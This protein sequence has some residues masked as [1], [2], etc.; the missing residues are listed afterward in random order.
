[1]KYPEI[2][3][4]YKFYAYYENSLSVLINRT[5]WSAKPDSFNDP[6][7]CKI[8]FNNYINLQE[9]EHFLPRY[10]NFKGISEKQL[11]EEMKKIRDSRGQVDAEFSKIWSIVLQASDDQL[12]N[13][14]VFCLSQYN[15]NILMWSHYAD[16]HK[17]FCI[18]F[19][20]SSQNDL[21][22][23]EKTRRVRYRPDYPSISPLSTD[24]FD[25][26]FFTK[27]LDWKYEKEWRLVNEEGNI[28]KPL[29]GDISA[30]IFGLRMAERHKETI[31]NIMTDIPNIRYRQS[32]KMPNQFKLK[33]IDL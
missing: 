11:E 32:T 13:S 5:V 33:V 3:R 27:A 12:G 4:L 6:F 25:L 30:I 24:A 21:G 1:M 31:K 9:L 8:P 10:K 7:D 18:E 16:N 14:G 2:T 29:P 26:K 20:R 19:V 22:D 17:G 23:Y 15:T 28:E